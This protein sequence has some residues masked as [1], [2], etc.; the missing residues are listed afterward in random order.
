V[1]QANDAK[2]EFGFFDGYLAQA[3]KFEQGFKRGEQISRIDL[4]GRVIDLFG[5][6]T[7]MKSDYEPHE[8]R[9]FGSGPNIGYALGKAVLVR[10]AGQKD[11]EA[12]VF[13]AYLGPD[14][15]RVRQIEIS[16]VCKASPGVLIQAIDKAGDRRESC[17]KVMYGE[18]GPE[19]DGAAGSSAAKA[20]PEKFMSTELIETLN[21]GVVYMQRISSV[22]GPKPE[23]MSQWAAAV[24]TSIRSAY[25]WY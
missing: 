25:H 15:G 24:R 21:A 22:D 16:E 17:H 20:A 5:E 12:L 2:I 10:N 1:A 3:K 11:E 19:Q 4:N 18:F 13:V 9:M 8:I 6:W 23:S 7:V 14:R